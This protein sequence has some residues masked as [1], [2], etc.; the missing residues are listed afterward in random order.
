M[1]RVT[2]H[3]FQSELYLDTN[4]RESETQTGEC[5]WLIAAGTQT[6]ITHVHVINCMRTCQ[7]MC[8]LWEWKMSHYSAWKLNIP[9]IF[10][11]KEGRTQIAKRPGALSLG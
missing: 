1:I 4:C 11:N 6:G 2:L 7:N 8:S 10:Q 5:M 3:Q 9:S